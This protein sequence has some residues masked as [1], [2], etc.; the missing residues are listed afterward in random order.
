MRRRT[1]P[2]VAWLPKD[3]G[4][5]LLTN[6]DTKNVVSLRFDFGPAGTNETITGIAPVVFDQTHFPDGSGGV[7]SLADIESSGYRLRRI[8]GKC[9]VSVVQGEPGSTAPFL[10][11]CGGAFIVLRTDDTGQPAQALSTYDLFE[12]GNDDSPWIWR[13]EWIL[14]DGAS[15]GAQG[16]ITEDWPF[17]NAEYGSVADGPHIDQKTARVIGQD[18]RLFFVAS[19]MNL[20]PPREG[21]AIINYR[22]TPRIL[23]SM[24]T[25]VGNRRNASR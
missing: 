11:L 25:S 16:P 21:I 2:K 6:S 22:I 24:R 18:E 19:V 8:V 17:T 10:L 23:A 15:L 20:G 1:K 13:R 3:P 4:A 14:Q 12:I 9:F 5:V 7:N